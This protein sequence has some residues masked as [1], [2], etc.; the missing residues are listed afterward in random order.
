MTQQ[1]NEQAQAAKKFINPGKLRNSEYS[2]LTPIGSELKIILN[3]CAMEGKWEGSLQKVLSKKWNKPKENYKLW[4][5][6]RQN[7]KPNCSDMV[8]VQSDI[9][10]FNV[11][12]HKEG[13]LV[14]DLKKVFKDLVAQAKYDKG[15]IHISSLSLQEVPEITPELLKECVLDEGVNIFMYTD[16]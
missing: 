7:F 16:K 4:F 3:T 6:N 9:W 12:T 13:Q 5:A 8:S 1:T 11:L 2:I 15:S 10:V 14:A